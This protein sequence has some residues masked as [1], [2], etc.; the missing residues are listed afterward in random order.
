[1]HH[2]GAGCQAIVTC[3]PHGEERSARLKPRGSGLSHMPSVA[4]PFETGQVALLRVRGGWSV[5]VSFPSW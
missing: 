4:S 2:D 1:M 5:T 3:S